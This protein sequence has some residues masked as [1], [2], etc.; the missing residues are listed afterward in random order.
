MSVTAVELPAGFTA[1]D[2]ERA[3]EIYAEGETVV[4]TEEFAPAFER[5]LA[6]GRPSLLHVRIDPQAL[7]MS[8]SLD[9]LRTQG[10]RAQRTP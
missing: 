6:A 1:D 2:V 10:E 5:A 8:A 4:R 7:T 9:A 3:A